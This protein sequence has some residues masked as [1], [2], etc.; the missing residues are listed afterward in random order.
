MHAIAPYLSL[1]GMS[2]ALAG[3]ILARNWLFVGAWAS[4]LA[5]TV[6]DKFRPAILPQPLVEVFP[7]V[8]LMLAVAGVVQ[9]RARLRSAR[10][11][12]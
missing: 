4:G 8:M 11:Q 1:V 10:A 2:I 7:Y 12:G 3:S 6:F 9:L 5:Y